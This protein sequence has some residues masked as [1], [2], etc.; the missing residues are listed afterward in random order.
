MGAVQCND[1]GKVVG[2]DVG[3]NGK[4]KSLGPGGPLGEHWFH[5]ENKMQ[6][7]LKYFEQM[8]DRHISF[9]CTCQILHF[10]QIEGMRQH[11]TN[12]S[13]PFFQQR[14]LTWYFCVTLVILPICKLVP[15]Y[16]F[17]MVICD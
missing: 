14:L 2:S 16:F 8:T 5:P 7:P 4:L 3:K 15:Y 1:S 10:L 13:G 17:V 9:Y 12:L 11:Q 6:S